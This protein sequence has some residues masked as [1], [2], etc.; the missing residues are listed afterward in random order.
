MTHSKHLGVTRER[1]GMVAGRGYEDQEMISCNFL[2][3]LEDNHQ[4]NVFFD[5]NNLEYRE[6]N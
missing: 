5:D 2:V 1:N 3:F 6:K 4:E